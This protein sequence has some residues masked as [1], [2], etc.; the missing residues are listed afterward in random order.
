MAGRSTLSIAAKL[1]DTSFGAEAFYGQYVLAGYWEAG[2]MADY[3]RA[4]LTSGGTLEYDHLAVAGDFMFRLASNRFRSLSIYTGAGVFAG[5]ETLDP[6][7]RL[8]DYLEL[9]VPG[10][11]FLYGIYGKASAE[12]YLGTRF[13]FTLAASVPMTFSSKLG[14]LRWNAGAGVKIIL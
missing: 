3:Y 11:N 12:L 6:F 7:H 2:V 9:P 8:P 14:W 4:T 5:L 1:H 10:K 13:A